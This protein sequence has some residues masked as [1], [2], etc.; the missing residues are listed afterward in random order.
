MFD[1]PYVL[2]SKII[3][4][5]SDSRPDHILR[6]GMLVQILNVSDNENALPEKQSVHSVFIG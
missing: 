4:Y 1:L 5:V 2:L 3:A 6:E